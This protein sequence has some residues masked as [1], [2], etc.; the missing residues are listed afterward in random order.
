MLT[1]V[2]VIMAVYVTQHIFDEYMNE[3]MEREKRHYY[4]KKKQ[5]TSV[6]FERKHSTK[7]F[8]LIFYFPKEIN[9]QNW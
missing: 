1:A 3:H 9:R 6:I 7:I 4:R 5:K 8:S 2:T